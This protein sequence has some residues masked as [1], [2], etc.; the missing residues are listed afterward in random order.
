MNL[1]TVIEGY[2]KKCR[3]KNSKSI[4]SN[5]RVIFLP[6]VLIKS[7]NGK[8]IKWS[9][10]EGNEEKSIVQEPKPFNK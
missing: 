5:Y 4:T 9:L 1:D 6:N 2:Q 7:I 10:C 8:S 3:I